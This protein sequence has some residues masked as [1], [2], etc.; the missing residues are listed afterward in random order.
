MVDNERVNRVENGE[1]EIENLWKVIEGT[2]VGNLGWEDK[3]LVV[4]ELHEGFGSCGA[5]IMEEERPIAFLRVP[6]ISGPEEAK[7]IVEAYLCSGTTGVM[8]FVGISE[9]RGVVTIPYF[10]YPSEIGEIEIPGDLTAIAQVLEPLPKGESLTDSLRNGELDNRELFFK[11]GTKLRELHGEQCNLTDEQF[12][13]W[14]GFSVYHPVE[15]RERLGDITAYFDFKEGWVEKDQLEVIMGKMNSVAGKQEDSGV[16]IVRTH[17][18]A[19]RDNVWVDDV[20]EIHLFDNAVAF[21]PRALD[22]AFA[23]GDQVARGLVEGDE[24]AFEN[25]EAFFEGYGVDGGENLK[26]EV[27]REFFVP[28]V[29]KLVVGAAFDYTGEEYLEKRSRLVKTAE[30]LLELKIKESELRFDLEMLESVWENIGE[31]N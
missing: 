20:G 3:E 25:V 15:G 4:G 29:F 19:W 12:G 27:M 24:G 28:L 18:D 13:W 17:G 21:G 31:E 14:R 6:E 9:S 2:V 11:F 16:L 8:Q 22:L 30:R 23:V 1:S 5:L 7:E 10:Q 26:Q